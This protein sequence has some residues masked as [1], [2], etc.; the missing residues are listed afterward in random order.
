MTKIDYD[1]AREYAT[2][3]ITGYGLTRSETLL[4]EDFMENVFVLAMTMKEGD[5]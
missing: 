2:K 3:Y 5:D 4:V 1:V